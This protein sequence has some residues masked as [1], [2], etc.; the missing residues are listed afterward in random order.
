MKYLLD[1]NVLREIGRA[2][3]HKNVASWFA[4]V[5]DADLALC[6]LSVREIRKGVELLRVT[7]PEA[8][9]GLDARVG[10]LFDA[11][12]ERVLSVD[13]AVADVWGRL[14]AVSGKHVDDAGLAACATVYGL[15]LVTRNTEDFRGRG[16]PVLNP[17][18]SPP[19]RLYEPQS[20][21]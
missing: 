6:A 7:K 15:T 14:L 18:K 4:S 21:Q 20:Q 13:Q 12:G 1:T 5:D 16:V 9:R 8:A 2:N 11:F 17:Y 19:E 10:V 3:P